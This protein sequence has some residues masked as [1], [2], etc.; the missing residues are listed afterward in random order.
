MSSNKDPLGEYAANRHFAEQLKY[1]YPIERFKHACDA[2]S[3]LEF[4][5]LV[6]PQNIEITDTIIAE[7]T[8]LN[9]FGPIVSD[10]PIAGLGVVIISEGKRFPTGRI[11]QNVK[12][13]S[14]TSG[15]EGAIYYSKSGDRLDGTAHQVNFRNPEGLM[16][17]KIPD[18]KAGLEA[19][20]RAYD[21]LI[22]DSII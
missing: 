1:L 5:S 17:I 7:F 2:I 22:S 13:R 15:Y 9:D 19:A 12:F 3:E 6:R 21:K 11:A 4:Q 16:D 8:R 14:D 20:V 18:F 10:N